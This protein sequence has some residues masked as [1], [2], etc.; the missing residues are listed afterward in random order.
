MTA[1]RPRQVARHAAIVLAGA[2]S[3][4]LTV[5]AGA[6]IVHEIATTEPAPREIAAPTPPLDSGAEIPARPLL[7]DTV[8][9]GGSFELPVLFGRTVPEP[10][11]PPNPAEP[12][13]GSIAG[14]TTP[15]GVS[16]KLGLGTTYVGAY[17][18]PVRTNTIAVTF[19]TNVLSAL[20][21]FLLAEP[22][23]QQLGVYADP[24]G[25]TQLRTEIDANRGEVVLAFSDP[26][27][28][29]HTLHV[30]GGPAPQ[31]TPGDTAPD[32]ADQRAFTTPPTAQSSATAGHTLSD[33]PSV[34]PAKIPGSAPHNTIAV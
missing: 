7:S 1:Q 26:T 8:L 16:G 3:L 2:A 22:V 19:D 28:G 14:P 12:L 17:V 18:G 15:P 20:S 25:I 33:T 9:T 32:A 11:V 6:Y 4:S 34:E 10:V 21:G 13:T 29:T 30:T 23:R 24:A 5:T 27:L 31:P